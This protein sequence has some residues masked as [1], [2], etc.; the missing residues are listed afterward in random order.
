MKVMMI[1]D[2]TIKEVPHGGSEWVNQVIIDKFNIPF[3]YSRNIKDFDIDTFYIISNIS[4]MNKQLI[5]EIKNF[6]YMI[7][8]NDYKICESRHPWRYTNNII[9][10]NERINYDLYKNSKAVLVQ[11]TDHMNVFLKNDVVA[12]FVN[13]KSS[14]W[15]DNDLEMLENILKTKKEKNNKYAI[16][17]TSNWIKNTKGAIDFCLKNKYEFELIPNCNSRYEF[18]DRLSN[19]SKL[20]FLPIARETFC[21]LVVEARCLE[22]PVITTKNYGAVLEDWFNKYHGNELID[23]LRYNTSLNLGLIDLII[24]ENT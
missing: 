6:N 9:P 15:S 7:I 1:S 4:L 21:R 14:I 20:I 19:C 16:Y 12:N 11:T 13:L 5:S 18:L 2:F 3:E 10:I 22:L 8:E 24:K 17:N 23:F